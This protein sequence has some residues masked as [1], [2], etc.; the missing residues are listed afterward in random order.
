MPSDRRFHPLTVLFALAGQLRAFL[1]PI[2]LATFTAQSRGRGAETWF[3]IF[4]IPGLGAAAGRYWFSTY[5]YDETELVVRT[6][7]F[8][9]NERHIPYARIQSV[10]AVQ[11]VMHRFF[12]V[13]DVKVQT[14][15][16]GEAEATLSVLPMSAL[17]EMRERVFEGKRA[18]VA[19]EGA[20]EPAPEPARTILTLSPRELALSGVLDNRGWVVIGAV[21]GLAAESG[22]FERIESWMPVP[23]TWSGLVPIVIA[24]A[25]GLFVISPM[26]SLVWATIRLYG[27]SLSQ[28]GADLCVEYGAFT[29][30]TATIPL[31][32]VQAVKIA[33]GLG[34]L[35]TGR[36]AVR[37]E[38]A[39]GGTSAKGGG[40]E[41][42]WIAPILPVSELD[43]LVRQILPDVSLETVEWSPVAGRAF[44][45]RARRSSMVA[46]ALG[47]ATIPWAGWWAAAITPALVV[48]G[49]FLARQYVRGL[50][51]A[52]TD[53]A[54]YFRS[55]WLR[56]TIT[57][58]PLPKIQCVQ[59][60]ES[61]FDRRH[62]M[63][64][65]SV[66][67]AG[68]GA[69]PIRVPYLMHAVA[70]AM[71]LDLAAH[72]ATTEYRW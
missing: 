31:R 21:F 6:G 65:L 1:V 16:G 46:F 61:P 53:H 22:L 3:L 26:L 39:G 32:R 19:T 69:H 24:V 42:E 38:T 60:V 34:H 4:L 40:S 44:L 11:N 14:G 72:A 70:D 15:T 35:W 45:R 41:R 36:A 67:T 51:W 71:R 29:R 23:D 57:I 9:K 63:A 62:A 68:A 12:G 66:D 33:R 7:I 47:L 25:V 5:R 28:R 2:L 56:R 10:D 18:V 27:F 43:S 37:V 20:S 58:V 13:V 52:R 17:T 48:L 64:S 30:V 59:L 8:F 54:M 55:G 49:I 50:G